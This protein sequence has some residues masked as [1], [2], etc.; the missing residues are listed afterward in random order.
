MEAMATGLVVIVNDI[1]A[2]RE[3][4]KDGETGFL[5]DYKNFETASTQI[6]DIMKIDLTNIERNAKDSAMKYDWSSTIEEFDNVD[7]KWKS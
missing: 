4:I 1:D 2:F 7:S 5:I 3:L 6:S